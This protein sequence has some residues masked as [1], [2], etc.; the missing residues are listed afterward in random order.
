MVGYGSTTGVW[1]WGS[2]NCGISVKRALWSLYSVRS[3]VVIVCDWSV[4]FGMRISHWSNEDLV[5]VY[6]GVSGSPTGVSSV[7]ARRAASDLWKEVWC[8]EGVA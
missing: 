7:S 1:K 3:V 4:S 6:V 8:H 2:L 5:G